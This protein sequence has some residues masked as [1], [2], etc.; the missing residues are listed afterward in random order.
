[1]KAARIKLTEQEACAK[2]HSPMTE[3]QMEESWLALRREMDRSRW[4][5]EHNLQP[6]EVGVV[7]NRSTG[8][9]FFQWAEALK[10]LPTKD[11]AQ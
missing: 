10:F 9:A 5:K 4:A 1:V 3:S 2:Y 7:V 11:G 8:T 6:D